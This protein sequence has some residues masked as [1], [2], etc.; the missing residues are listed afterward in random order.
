MQASFLN[1]KNKSTTHLDLAT[2]T[3]ERRN[4][5]RCFQCQRVHHFAIR[6]E[7][8]IFKWKFHENCHCYWIN[9]TNIYFVSKLFA[10]PFNGI[11]SISLNGLPHASTTRSTRFDVF[12][13]TKSFFFH[14][15]SD[16]IWISFFHAY[17]ISRQF[18]FH[19]C[20]LFSIQVN[21]RFYFAY[22]SFDTRQSGKGDSSIAF[23]IHRNRS[24][25]FWPCKKASSCLSLLEADLG[26]RGVARVLK[27]SKFVWPMF[28]HHLSADHKFQYLISSHFREFNFYKLWNFK[29]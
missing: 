22:S 23:F 8:S 10:I 19:I 28:P 7:N 18:H 26:K 17:W 1:R 27:T 29:I 13:Q 21:K 4:P 12:L 16:F 3:A 24:I 15:R 14:L 6:S 5:L 11:D 9:S 25:I 20:F 2:S